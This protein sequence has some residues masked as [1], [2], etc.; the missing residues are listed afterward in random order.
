MSSSPSNKLAIPKLGLGTWKSDNQT[1]MA[2]VEHAIKV[3]YRH[4]DCAPIYM[5]EK[6]IGKAIQTAIQSNSIKREDLWITSKLWNSFHDPD[7]VIKALK[8]TLHFMQLDYL[9]LYLMHWPVAAHHQVGYRRVTDGKELISLNDI[10]LHETWLAMQEAHKLGLAKHL[11]VSNFTANKIASL[12]EK[13]GIT[14]QVNQVECHPYLT[15]QGL[16]DYCH[17]NNI[18]LTAYAP[19]GSGDRPEFLKG[20]NEPKLLDNPVILQCAKQSACT[21]GQLLLAWS[22]QHVDSTIPKSTN[23]NRILENFQSQSIALSN[24]QV[25]AINQLNLN[26]RFISGEFFF[27]PNSPYEKEHFWD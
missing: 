10:P 4:I 3:G 11:G 8:E 16:V 2:A 20:E 26:F 7:H 23:P 17:H 1:V 12:I 18:H 19:L 25:E 14:P 15:Q 6:P 5:N 9:D 13:T 21:P 27:I 22:M 24:N